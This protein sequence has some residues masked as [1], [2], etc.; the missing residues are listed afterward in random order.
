[1]KKIPQNSLKAFVTVNFGLEDLALQEVQELVSV[2][3]KKYPGLILFNVTSKD[4][5]LRLIKHGQSFK[6]VVLFLDQQKEV[7]NFK[8]EKCV[9]EWNDFF[10]SELSLKITVEQVKGN[11]NRLQISRQVMGNLFKFIESKLKFTPAIELKR[12]DADVLVVKSE[13]EYFL[14]LDLCGKDLNSRAYRVFPNQASFKGDL[15]YYFVRLC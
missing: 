14:G 7:E 1:M 15:G 9:I 2:K 6:R 12:P 3:G 10:T 8:L 11:D 13:E 4:D 5:L